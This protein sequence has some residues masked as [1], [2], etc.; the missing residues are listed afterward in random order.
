[1]NS[2]SHFFFFSCILKISDLGAG[3]NQCCHHVNEIGYREEL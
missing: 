1:M 2:W 3:F